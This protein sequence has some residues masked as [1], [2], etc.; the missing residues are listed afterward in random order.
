METELVA[1]TTSALADKYRLAVVL[2][3]S[4]AETLSFGSLQELTGLS[5]PCVSH[6][7]KILADSGLVISTKQGRCV[8]LSLN[9]AALQKLAGF[10][11]QLG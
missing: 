1:R 3:L 5:Q 10:L 11:S 6:H 8:Q 2:A 4:R 9:R 7:L